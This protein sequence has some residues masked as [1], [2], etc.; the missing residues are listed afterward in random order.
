M[1]KLE[2]RGIFEVIVMSFKRLS[3]LVLILLI[4]CQQA[5]VIA[6]KQTENN[7][8]ANSS[9][10][11]DRQLQI[12]KSA[13]LE[14]PGE[15]IQLDAAAILLQSDDTKARKVLLEVL[16]QSENTAARTAVCKALSQ[17]RSN[18]EPIKNKNDF[19]QPLFEMLAS[20]DSSQ[21]K[22]AA[23]AMLIFDYEQVGKQLQT[24]VNDGTEPAKSRLNAIYALRLQPDIRA[25]STLLELLDDS[26]KQVAAEAEKA[27]RS[28]GI[29]VGRDVQSR[30]MIVNEL[31]RKGR[32]VFLRDWL[33]RQEEQVRKLEAEAQLWQKMY[34]DSLD[35]IYESLTTD[36]AKAKFLAE[37][38]ND[39]KVSIKLWAM[40]KV[41][42][43]RVGT[44]AKL[45]SDEIATMLVALVSNE[46]RDIRLK[47]A[48]LLSLMGEINSAEKLL[49]QVK[50][51]QDEEVKAELFVALGGACYY[52][53]LPNSGIKIAP[54]I[55]KQT[56]AIAAQYLA[57]DDEKQAQKGAEVIKK[58]LEQDGLSLTE[59]ESYLG[60]LAQ[61]YEQQKNN[62]NSVLRG[63]LLSYMASLC[64]QSVY[65]DE[66]AKRFEP[67]FEQ[68]LKDQAGLVREAA[69]DGL[70]YIDKTTALQLLRK[71]FVNDDSAA[72]RKKLTDLAAEVG[73]RR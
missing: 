59:A 72:V 41:S 17:A 11:S 68:A 7:A 15:Q 22:L 34:L 1:I 38:L 66:A 60:L 13:L 26:D 71:D 31:K 70:I 21:G 49:E 51:E 47:T 69:M 62:G 25:I 53:F 30:R 39:P 50:V 61:K 45:P 20:E 48:G 57:S 46:N 65:K 54:E 58:L 10:D 32:D 5:I 33:L 6:D 14:G 2:G 8:R 9:A 28:L 18:R 35:K 37:Q 3:V 36:E 23:E 27:I 56:L 12:N 52:A 16:L 24:I 44:R 43:W 29:P 67:L 40:E 19:L 63:E 55:K 42:Q 73:C 4:G 64:A